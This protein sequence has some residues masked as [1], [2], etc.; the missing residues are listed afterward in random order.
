MS[1]DPGQHDMEQSSPS[2]PTD[3][4][5]AAHDRKISPRADGWQSVAWVLLG[6]ATLIESL[7]M[8]R[9]EQQDINPYTIPGLLPACLGV[10]IILL[11]LLMAYR[12]ISRGAL[13]PA[14]QSVQVSSDGHELRRIWV[15]LMLCCGFALGMVGHGLSFWCAAA[16]FITVTVTLLQHRS[17]GNPRDKIKSVVKAAIIGV[18]AGVVITL[19]FQEFFLVRLP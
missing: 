10:A 2:A 4:E 19:V 3:S 9:L 8:D 11:G 15:I 1:A 18:T 6:S 13:Q 12:S 5:Q 16:V 7:R 14:S 17:Q